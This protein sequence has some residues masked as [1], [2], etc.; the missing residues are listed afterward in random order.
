MNRILIRCGALALA[1]VAGACE[2]AVQNPNNPGTEQVKT[3]PADLENYL[4]TQYRRWHAAMYSSLSNVGGMAGVQ[5]FEDFSSLSNNC[6]GQRVIIPRAANDNSIGNGCAT[7]QARIYLIESEVARGVSDVLKKLDDPDYSFGSD[8]QDLRGVAFAEFLRGLSLGYLALIYDSAAVIKPTDPLR[9]DGT[10]DPGELAGYK[11]VMAE[12]LVAL[13]NAEAATVAAGTTG[14]NGFPLPQTWINGPTSFTA[15]EFV[16]LI[17][18]Y[19]A[20]LRANNARTPAERAAVDWDK[21][22]ADAQGGITEDHFNTTSSITGPSN[23]WVNNWYSYTTW[24]QMTP[25]II[26]MADNSGAYATWIATPIGTRG[27]GTPFFMTTADQRFPQGATRAAQQA[28][29]AITS[30]NTA[31]TV[32]KRYFRNRPGGNDN[33]TPPSW[34]WSNYDHTRFWPWRTAGDGGTAANGKFPFFTKAELDLLQAEGQYRKQNY[35][36]AAALINITRTRVPTATQPGGQLPA[37][38]AFDATTPVPG[39]TSCVPRVPSNASNAGG[40]T[41]ACGNMWEALKWEKRIE[42]AYTHFMA[43]FL[44]SRGWGDLVVGTGLHWPPPF[45]ELQARGRIGAQIYSTGGLTGLTGAAATS[46]Y[47]W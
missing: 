6:M 39:G 34:G 22:I 5:S 42:T 30:C 31:G 8:A 32:C 29:F 19:R 27:A 36:A 33:T 11:D 16:K 12:A 13:D 46:T 26:G 24:H 47:G 4:G 17:K 15:T 41:V 45:S 20:R 43:W 38:V 10:S 9:A 2:L 7:E 14:P 37:I 25:F 1:V 23:T 35:A 3:T 21:V 40:A 28:D 44:D 18:S